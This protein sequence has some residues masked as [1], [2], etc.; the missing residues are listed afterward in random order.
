MASMTH[1]FARKSGR[2]RPALEPTPSLPEEVTGRADRTPVVSA[3][4]AVLSEAPQAPAWP[5]A[6][7]VWS[8]SAGTVL[9]GYGPAVSDFL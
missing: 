2:R 5:G 6:V 4:A 3:R 1:P 9:S 7:Q 8:W